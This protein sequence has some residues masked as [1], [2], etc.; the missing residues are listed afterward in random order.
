M[1]NFSLE[2]VF[3]VLRDVREKE[4]W[5]MV[6]AASCWSIWLTRNDR[7]F[8]TK[9]SDPKVLHELI[10][11]I[12]NKWGE[13]TKLISF[14]MDPMWRVNPRGAIKLHNHIES[15]KF[16]RYKFDQFE[17]VATVDGAWS[18]TGNNEILVVIGG[19]FK[20]GGGKLVYVFSGPSKR[21]S[22]KEAKIEAIA[23]VIGVMLLK[24][25]NMHKIAMCSD[26]REAI[27]AIRKVETN[28]FSS[29][30]SLRQLAEIFNESAHLHHV[31]REI[32]VEADELMKSGLG[33][34][35]IFEYWA[36]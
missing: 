13:A 15:I 25:F 28:S 31:P 2:G 34:Q 32:N 27:N 12:V 26:S 36:Q 33:K 1:V 17:M 29:L 7:L 35:K 4:I 21:I 18:V 14:R 23:H 3:K 19:N 22:C 11:V 20:T 24:N 16:W 6:V 30:E 8:V 10:R 9:K 5:K